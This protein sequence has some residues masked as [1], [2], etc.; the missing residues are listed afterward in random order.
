MTTKAV[1]PNPLYTTPLGAAYLGDSLEVLPHFPPGSVSL[2]VT[3]PPYAL[4]FKKEYGNVDQGQYVEW[5]LPFARRLQRLLKDDGSLVIDLGGAWQAGQPTRSLYHF[6]LLIALCRQ[7]GFHLA[8][9]FFWYNPAKLPSP[10]EW[11]NVRKIRVKDAVECLWWLSKTPWPKANNQRVLQ[12]YSADMHRLLQRGYRAKARPSGHRII[13]KFKD[14]GG[15]IPPNLIICG[16]NDA[17]GH[18]LSRCQ[19]AGLKPHP[20]RFPQKIPLFF[21]NFLTDPGDLVLDPFAGSNTTGEAAEK[22]GRRWIAV[23]KDELYLETSKFRFEPKRP[24]A[25]PGAAPPASNGVPPKKRGRK[26]KVADNQAD[27]FRD[28]EPA[29]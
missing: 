11:V 19:A 15:S 4:H 23:E 20:A 12:E 3:S 27:L 7:V 9:E 13:A 26:K 22:A 16:N 21:I 1:E 17:N 29:A 10:A 18:Y 8:Q 24:P 5:F 6:E 2:V 28:D 14:N 25:S